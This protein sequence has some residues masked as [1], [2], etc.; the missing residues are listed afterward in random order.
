MYVCVRVCYVSRK[1]ARVCVQTAFT[2]LDEK[3]AENIFLP[4]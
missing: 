1:G 4:S 2:L 3:H